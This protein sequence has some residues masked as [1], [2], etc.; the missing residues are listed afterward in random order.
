MTVTV[1]PWGSFEVITEGPGYVVKRLVIN[2]GGR[3]SLQRHQH[4]EE[5]MTLV[6]GECLVTRNFSWDE[7]DLYEERYVSW[8]DDDFMDTVF[9]GRKDWHRIHNPTDKECVIIEVWKGDH[10]SEEDIERKEDDY[11]RVQTPP[12]DRGPG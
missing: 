9:I 11:G 2:P 7:N 10:L 8:Y 5:T 12:S 4:R 3:T 1:R 6:Q